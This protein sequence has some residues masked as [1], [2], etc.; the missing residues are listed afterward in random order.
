MKFLDI[1]IGFHNYISW[2]TDI[3]EARSMRILFVYTDL[4]IRGGEMSYQM[5]IGRISAMLKRYGHKIALEHQYKK[6]NPRKLLEHIEAFKPDIVA[7]SSISPQF[8]F[9]RGLLIE[10]K[11]KTGVYT[12]LGGNHASLYPQ[13]FDE[14]PEI[15]AICRGEGEE[16]MVEFVEKFEHGED[17]TDVENFWVRSD[18]KIYKNP[19]RPFVQNLD[20][21]PFPDRKLFDY[22]AVINSNYDRA[23]FLFSR[24]C[25]Y[26]CTYC[27]N[28]RL[29]DLQEGKYVRYRSV[30]NVLEEIKQVISKYRVK[31]VFM[32]DDTFTF[33]KQLVIDFCSRY[34]KEVALPLIVHTRVEYASPEMFQALK[35]AGCYR[36][37]FGIESGDEEF[38]KDVLNRKM[39]N[40]QIRQAFKLA[41]EAG[42]LTKSFNI[43]GFPGE[44]KEMHQKTI[45]LNIEIDPD[46]FTLTIFDPYPG[47]QMY[48][49]CVQK[50]YLTDRASKEGFIP[51]TDTVLDMPQFSRKEILK[52]YRNFAYNIYKHKSI[53]K[54]IIFKIYYS[55]WGE[56]IIRLLGPLKKFFFRI[57]EFAYRKKKKGAELWMREAGVEVE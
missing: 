7:Y 32:Q 23:D 36:I 18:G 43:V 6:Y 19:C 55:R 33:N 51:R 40:D 49:L 52:C 12:V 24:G 42:F 1:K 45:N 34:K 37:A 48:D 44:T 27:S 25:P 20:R 31:T 10:A 8:K 11:R 57:A 38:R 21:L 54:A 14:I 9:I 30:D 22:Q 35:E 16:A 28:H 46:L 47:T 4:D 26:S 41:K 39:T 29:R 17:I 53:K 2:R 50:G 5:G 3:A 15:D 13:C 56:K